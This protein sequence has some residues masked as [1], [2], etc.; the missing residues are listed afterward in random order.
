MLV[1]SS[2]LKDGEEDP[3]DDS[4]AK[5]R[6]SVGVMGH[7]KLGA[8]YLKRLGF[9]Q[10][11]CD[12]VE[13]HVVAKRYLTA[14]DPDY[15]AA[16]SD[17]SK[18][19]LKFQ[20]GPFS[21][22]AV[23]AFESDPLFQ[24]KVQ[25]RKWDDAS[26]VVGL[27]T[28]GLDAYRSMA[29][30]H[31]S[32]MALWCVYR[33]RSSAL[34]D[35]LARTHG[36]SWGLLAKRAYAAE[37]S[38]TGKENLFG[39]S[40]HYFAKIAEEMNI[41]AYRS[42]QIHEWIYKKGATTFQDMKNLPRTVQ[43]ELDRRFRIDYGRVSDSQ[44]SIDGTRKMLIQFD[45]DPRASVE[46]V[47]IPEESRGTL[48]VSSQI[49]CSLSCR[50]CH[51]GTQ[52]LYRNLTSAEIAGQ[53]MIAAW[54]SKDFP[55]TT[56]HQPKVSNIVFMGQGEPLYNF[57]NVSSAIGVLTD[58]NAV[59]LAP[60]RITISTSGVAPLIPRIASDLRVGLAI[61][62]HSADNDLRSEIMPIN[63]TYPLKLL[64]SS[65]REFAK[66]AS[67]QTRRITFEY[68]MLD[69]VNDS[70]SDAKR[71]VNLIRDL[72]AHVN[73]IP[74]NPWPG[75]AYRA[76]STSRVAEFCDLIRDLGIH[77]SGFYARPR[78]SGNDGLDMMYWECCVPGKDGTAWE[79]GFYKCVLIFNED[80]PAS[81]PKCQFTPP[82]FH[83]NVF[84]SGTVCLS[85]L[86]ADKDWKPSITLKQILLGVQ[87]LLDEPNNSDPA[88]ADAYH[89]FKKDPVAY[90]K[91]VRHQAAQF[92][93]HDA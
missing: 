37:A 8:S 58:Q 23:Q 42:K 50:F 16:L 36:S 46:T 32:V 18:Q 64:M 2:D 20:G 76:S 78:K 19:S 87:S 75:S 11:I 30:T 73:L 91:K 56:N 92:S 86:S 9:S 45:E 77:A 54:M 48:C 55:R 38:H 24:Q 15:Y 81:P 47:F 53:Y 66:I 62:L 35:I 3:E 67:I 52:A 51:T 1:D 89:L 90:E 69:G 7:E 21:D 57:R 84:P 33:K 49:G 10:K 43:Q 29:V 71:L 60:W 22:E 28:P 63:K 14:V 65:C 34:C 72:P 82:I 13:S 68:V 39:K 70:D 93:K 44:L 85:I 40:Q 26:K 88:Q 27:E 31:L 74:F 25:L 5:K 17:A 12:L 4:S 6:V 41:P 59:G 80:Y 61:S 79:G 83:P